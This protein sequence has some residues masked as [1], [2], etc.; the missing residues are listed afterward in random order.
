MNK[1]CFEI[2]NCCQCPHHYQ[3]RI[4]TPDSWEH[5][6]GVYCSKVEDKKS[7]NKKHKL[8]AEDEWDVEKYS[9]IPNW[10]PLLNNK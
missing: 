2:D 3:E 10:C 5:D 9:K 4:W 1:V 7:Y 8:V 6:Y